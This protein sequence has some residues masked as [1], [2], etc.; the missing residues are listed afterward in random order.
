MGSLPM[1]AASFQYASQ[2]NWDQRIGRILENEGPKY[3]R[4]PCTW[5]DAYLQSREP[6]KQQHQSSG[7][8][9]MRN[10]NPPVFQNLFLG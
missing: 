4:V 8:T 6:M 7:D 1:R 5:Y 10:G 3:V 2:Q 9:T